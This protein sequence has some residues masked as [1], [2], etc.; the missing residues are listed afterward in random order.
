MRTGEVQILHQDPVIIDEIIK[1]LI[2]GKYSVKASLS[3]SQFIDRCINY[4]I[5]DEEIFSIITDDYDEEEAPKVTRF[6]K[7]KLNYKN[8][9]AII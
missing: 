7:R 2:N 6:L 4:N 5:K 9:N 1:I 3:N 8:G